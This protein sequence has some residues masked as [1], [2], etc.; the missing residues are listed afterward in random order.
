M[1]NQVKSA[2]VKT[3]QPFGTFVE[4]DGRTVLIHMIEQSWFWPFNPYCHFKKGDLCK[5]WLGK[6][7]GQ[8]GSPVEM[9]SFRRAYPELDPLGRVRIG[10][11]LS[12]TVVSVGSIG[13]SCTLGPVQDVDFEPGD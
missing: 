1:S 8:Q 11:V 6:I 13:L 3:I 2:I 10:Q 7:L 4:V 12:A 5:I 9:A